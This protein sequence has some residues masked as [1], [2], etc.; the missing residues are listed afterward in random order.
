MAAQQSSFEIL[1][2]IAERRTGSGIISYH[3][4]KYSDDRVKAVLPH[5]LMEVSDAWL[6]ANDLSHGDTVLCANL[7]AGTVMECRLF[8]KPDVAKGFSRTNTIVSETLCVSPGDE[9]IVAK[10]QTI[11]FDRVM[12]QK[13]DDV[14][15]ECVSLSPGQYSLIDSSYSQY[16]LIHPATGSTYIINTEKLICS[17]NTPLGAV[18]LSM[19]Q[20]KLLAQD[21][22]V[23]IKPALCRQ[24]ISDSR[25]SP[26]EQT[27]IDELYSDD[28]LCTDPTRAQSEAIKKA[29][30]KVG[31]YRL[32]LLPVFESYMHDYTK[33]TS[34]FGRVLKFIVGGSNMVLKSA[35]PYFIDEN[36]LA[37]RLSRENMN[38]LGI[39]DMDEVI[40][41]CRNRSV[42]AKAMCADSLD[43]VRS[44]NIIGHDSDGDTII[45][46]PV[47]LRKQLGVRDLNVSV[48]VSR[49]TRFLFRKNLNI[50]LLPTIALLFTLIQTFQNH[51][52]TVKDYLILSAVFFAILPVV[53]YI[54][55]SE[56]RNKVK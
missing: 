7:A 45:G 43:E 35:R 25:L 41:S 18:R 12:T 54:V 23:A 30:A 33:D 39:E 47:F 14:F 29:L 8:A 3:S 44:N 6:K 37:V 21:A 5:H 46:I 15:S 40:V 31:Y 27:L 42:K 28:R 4:V 17:Q 55:F 56:V 36:K 49:S 26:E 51:L 19:M 1:T 50:Q 10:L 2:N 9:I 13:V 11:N 34:I 22:P 16:Q 20:R 24:I 32:S 53:I 52:H 38:L 48:K